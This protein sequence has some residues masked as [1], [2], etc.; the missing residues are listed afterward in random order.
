MIAGST[1]LRDYLINFCR[2]FIFS[3]ALPETAVHAIRE[4]YRLF[5]AMPAARQ[6]L[7]ALIRQWQQARLPWETLESYTP[8]QGVILPGNEAVKQ[9]AARLQHNNLDVRPILYPTVP[10]GRERL[11]IILHAFNTDAELQQLAAQLSA[12]KKKPALMTGPVGT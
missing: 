6:Q 12:L 5:P 11:R 4:S 10:R 9:M 7:N 2:P 8:I 1:Q 3:T